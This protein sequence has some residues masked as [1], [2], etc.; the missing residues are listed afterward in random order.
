MNIISLSGVPGIGENIVSRGL[1][2]AS[3]PAP[4][5]PSP[6]PIRPFVIRTPPAD[7][8]GGGGASWPAQQR[9]CE[10]WRES[11]RDIR[12][13]QEQREADK[14]RARAQALVEQIEQA[15]EATRAQQQPEVAQPVEQEVVSAAPQDEAKVEQLPIGIHARVRADVDG[16]VSYKTD[17]TV[18][19]VADD[20]AKYSYQGVRA[21]SSGP[22]MSR[23][24]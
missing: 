21:I 4:P 14:A 7:T 12:R 5:P 1:G 10:D 16:I 11:I 17:L 6:Q 9:W 13:K 23:P 24:P 19:I 3:A 2:P 15:A 20:G 22:S 8:S 18:E